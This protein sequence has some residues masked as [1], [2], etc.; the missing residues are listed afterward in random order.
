MRAHL[1]AA[2]ACSHDI[3]ALNT[4]S[5]VRIAIIG[6]ARL[7]TTTTS[8][9]F[10]STRGPR[11]SR[12]AMRTPRC[13]KNANPTGASQKHRPIPTGFL[14][15]SAN[16]C[17]CDRH[18]QLHAPA[19]R[20][21][22]ARHGKHVMCEK[23]LGLNAGRS[24]RNAHAARDAGVVHMTAFTYRFAP[25]MR[26][27][28]HLAATGGWHSAPLSQ[29][30]LSRLARNQLGLAANRDRPARATCST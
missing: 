11:S 25:A 2:L 1:G 5:P 28:A 26:H 8:P 10:G 15:G 13:S 17:R 9:R 12:P 23:P 27:L 18:A 24:P 30:T 20:G 22:A 4:S 7:A 19:D 3:M 14:R 29:P 21:S 6:A 16:R